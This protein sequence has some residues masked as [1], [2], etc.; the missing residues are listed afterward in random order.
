[1]PQI[2]EH[3]EKLTPYMFQNDVSYILNLIGKDAADISFWWL[4]NLND[5]ASQ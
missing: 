4:H 2:K 1:M 5:S 3:S